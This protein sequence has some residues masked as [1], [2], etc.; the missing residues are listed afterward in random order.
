M[1]FLLGKQ[2]PGT[3]T[4]PDAA[5]LRRTTLDRLGAVDPL[6]GLEGGKVP[7]AYMDLFQSSLAPVLAQ[8]KESAGN[9]TGS[10]L[11]NITGAAAGRSLSDFLLHLLNQ[12]GGRAAAL[13]GEAIAPQQAAYKPGFLDYLFQGAKAAAPFFAGPAGAI[14]SAVGTGGGGGPGSPGPWETFAAP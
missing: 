1:S 8:A 4:S 13:T 12:T 9:L 6:T 7:Q 5:N 3:M 2:V 10:G 11:G 14:A